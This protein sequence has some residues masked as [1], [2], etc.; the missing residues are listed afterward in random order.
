MHLQRV[1]KIKKARRK[2]S[3]RIRF[4]PIEPVQSPIDPISPMF[5]PPGIHHLF[6]LQ[7]TKESWAAT[8]TAPSDPARTSAL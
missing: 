3:T 4:R 2:K 5:E 6:A 8:P 7:K 1:A